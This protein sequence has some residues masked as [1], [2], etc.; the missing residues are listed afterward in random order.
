MIAEVHQEDPCKPTHVIIPQSKESDHMIGMVNKNVLAF[1]Y[2]MLLKLVF[3][4]DIIKN[5]LKKF[6]K[7]SLVADILNCK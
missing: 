5:L 4:E 1:L 2:H 7:A 6:C 3:T